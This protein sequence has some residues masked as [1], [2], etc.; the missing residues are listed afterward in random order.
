ME[1]YVCYYYYY[2]KTC[3]PASPTTP[4]KCSKCYYSTC[5]PLDPTIDFLWVSYCVRDPGPEGFNLW[6]TSLCQSPGECNYNRGAPDPRVVL[7]VWK[8]PFR[9]CLECL[10]LWKIREKL[11]GTTVCC[12]GIVIR[13]KTLVRYCKTLGY[14][15]DENRVS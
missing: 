3:Y 9:L 4:A 1:Q 15:E 8:A 14:F 2:S 10:E 5:F 13:P 6:K 12:N 7:L 11:G